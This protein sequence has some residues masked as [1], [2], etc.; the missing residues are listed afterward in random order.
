MNGDDFQKP[1]GWSHVRAK[2]VF[3]PPKAGRD[4]L[5]PYANTTYITPRNNKE[6]HSNTEFPH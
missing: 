5:H 2:L 6:G 4:E 1:N 3:A